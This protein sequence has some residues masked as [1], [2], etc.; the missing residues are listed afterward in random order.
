[1]L[2]EEEEGEGGFTSRRRLLE[3]GLVPSQDSL[4]LRGIGLMIVK[5]GHLANL[6]RG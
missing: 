5:C 3:D 2:V 1:M 4:A 6:W